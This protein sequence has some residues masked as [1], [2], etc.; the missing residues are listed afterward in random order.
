MIQIFIS[1]P[2]EIQ[3]R[4]SKLKIKFH[5]MKSISMVNKKEI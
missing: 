2:I 3:I 4:I 5:T 1:N